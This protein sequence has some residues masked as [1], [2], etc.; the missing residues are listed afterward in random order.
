[1]SLMNFS[2]IHILRRACLL[3]HHFPGCV[4]RSIFQRPQSVCSEEC[5]QA[6]HRG[7]NTRTEEKKHQHHCCVINKLTFPPG[8]GTFG[9]ARPARVLA[10][11]EDCGGTGKLLESSA[12]CAGWKESCPRA[13][14]W[15][16]ASKAISTWRSLD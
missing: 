2:H 16:T 1:M 10:V 9:P 4:H 11:S 8:G 7:A 15:I 14:G 3:G 5:W 6:P 12:V 13:S